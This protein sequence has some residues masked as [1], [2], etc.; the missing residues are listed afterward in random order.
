MQRAQN[1]VQLQ[2]LKFSK[3]SA[4]QSKRALSSSY[5]FPSIPPASSKGIDIPPR[6][7]KCAK[8]KASPSP[9]SPSEVITPTQEVIRKAAGAQSSASGRGSESAPLPS[10]DTEAPLAD[11]PT[12]PVTVQSLTRSSL[13]PG[14]FIYSITEEGDI[15]EAICEAPDVEVAIPE[16]STPITS[17]A[18]PQLDTSSGA[19]LELMRF[20]FQKYQLHP[21]SLPPSASTRKALLLRSL[22]RSSLHGIKECSLSKLAVKIDVVRDCATALRV[23]NYDKETFD[24]FE[25]LLKDVELWGIEALQC[26]FKVQVVYGTRLAS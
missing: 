8:T 10:I 26:E 6:P 14:D 24:R 13:S 4:R 16:I 20:P 25:G 23:V 11:S 12:D 22:L 19:A 21:S 17:D 2:S 1:P 5:A 3:K 9:I 15:T 18:E 7:K